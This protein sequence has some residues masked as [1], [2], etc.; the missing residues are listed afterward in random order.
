MILLIAFFFLKVRYR[1]VGE[2]DKKSNS[3]RFISCHH[4]F[5]TQ[6]NLKTK[7]EELFCFTRICLSFQGLC[8]LSDHDVLWLFPD[9]IH[10]FQTVAL[11]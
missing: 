6:F 4:L 11:H 5:C 7:S 9:I 3:G 2:E 1:A 10:K 8:L